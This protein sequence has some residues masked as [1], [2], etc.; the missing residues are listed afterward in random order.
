MSTRQRR[1]FSDTP[2]PLFIGFPRWLGLQSRSL[3]ECKS[4]L[5]YLRFIDNIYIYLI[6]LVPKVAHACTRSS[7]CSPILVSRLIPKLGFATTALLD[8]GQSGFI[9]GIPLPCSV[10]TFL[11]RYT[12]ISSISMTDQKSKATHSS[13][14]LVFPTLRLCIPVAAPSAEVSLAMFD[15]YHICTFQSTSHLIDGFPYLGLLYH[16][17]L[18]SAMTHRLRVDISLG[19]TRLESQPSEPMAC[20]ISW[21]LS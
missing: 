8:A 21:S 19:R 3:S 17:L 1:T 6:L 16:T 9:G 12:T 4:P 15:T 7:I 18:I 20:N 5:I 2:T 13:E 11:I 14:C 10:L